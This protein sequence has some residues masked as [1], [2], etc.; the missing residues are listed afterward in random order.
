M[1]PLH[2][3]NAPAEHVTTRLYC[4]LLPPP[5]GR[6]LGSPLATP[7]LTHT[8][9]P[10]TLGYVPGPPAAAAMTQFLAACLHTSP[11]PSLMLQKKGAFHSVRG[12]IRYSRTHFPRPKNESVTLPVR[13]IVHYVRGWIRHVKPDENMVYLL[14]D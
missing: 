9:S 13:L 3:D 5:L 6:P 7:T 2:A 12:M 8:L 14:S 11:F 4:F 10:N 1:N